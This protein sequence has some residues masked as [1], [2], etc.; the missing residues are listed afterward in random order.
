MLVCCAVACREADLRQCV[1]E[2]Y[3]LGGLGVARVGGQ[4]PGCAL[5]NLGD[6][7]AARDVGNPVAIARQWVACSTAQTNSREE[8]TVR[9]LIQFM[10]CWRRVAV[11]ICLCHIGVVLQIV[12]CSAQA[13][14]SHSTPP[15]YVPIYPSRFPRYAKS[16]V[17]SCPEAL[18][19]LMVSDCTS[20]AVP[21]CGYMGRDICVTDCVLQRG[22]D[23]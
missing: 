8:N 6:D 10:R 7:K 20:I 9:V 4:I 22:V 15:L 17:Q 11:S 18:R 14:S 21:L 1:F 2:P 16:F 12:R 19:T 13:H 3:A 5:G 23:A